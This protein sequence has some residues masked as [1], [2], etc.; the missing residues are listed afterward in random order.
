MSNYSFNN[1]YEQILQRLLARVDDS[2]DKREGSIIYDA[3]AP[4]AAELAQCYIAMDIYSNQSY[5]LDATGVNLDNRVA[6]YGLERIQA[7]YSQAEV[8]TYNTNQQLMSVPIGTRFATPNEYGGVNFQVIQQVTTGKY[9][10]QCET[11]GAVGNNYTGALLPLETVNNLGSAVISSIYKP[12]E[13]EE[14]DDTLRNR[15]LEKLNQEAFAGNKSAYRQMAIAIDG[16]E[17]AKV[18]PIWNGG[19]T[20]KLAIVAANHTIPSSSF[21]NQVQTLIDPIAN[22]G[23][24][25]GLAPIGHSVTVVAP[26][27]QNINIS[28]TLTLDTGYTIEQLQSA[29][30]E[31]LANYLYQVQEDFITENTLI[32]YLSKITAA[33]LNVS[34]VKNVSNLKINNNASDLTIN[35]TGTNVKY[36][37]LN[38]VTLSEST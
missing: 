24:G 2:L 9:I 28:A 30:E 6:D 8:L 5:L 14:T 16:V 31:Q 25:I 17:D 18:F 11:L 23:Q 13:D 26:T 10:A 1:S 21:I 29:I 4:A 37:M 7:T 22:Q 12:G 15:A 32:I 35:L 3:L 33:I 38:E 36:P 20:V 34:Q 19:G 27:K